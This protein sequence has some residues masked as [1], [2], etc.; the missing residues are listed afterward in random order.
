MLD[1]SSAFVTGPPCTTCLP[2]LVAA[3]VREVC[4]V[5]LME[6]TYPPATCARLR[7]VSDIPGEF[8]GTLLKSLLILK[9]AC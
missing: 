5:G 9:G 7:Q 6:K 3:G 2:L 1:G 8:Q 4:F